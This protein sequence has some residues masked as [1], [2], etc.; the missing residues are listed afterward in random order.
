VALLLLLA[1]IA[2]GCTK[3]T[4]V[5]PAPEASPTIQVQDFDAFIE[6]SYL[7]LLKRDPETVL[8]LGLSP[9][10]GTPTDQLTDISDE[11]IRETQALEVK[12]ST[13]LKGMTAQT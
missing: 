3:N 9:V 7:Q 4:P 6:D 10:L 12:S 11:Y 2:G 13:H 8:E 1:C 5:P